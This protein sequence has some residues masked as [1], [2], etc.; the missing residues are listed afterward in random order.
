M[1]RVQHIGDKIYNSHPSNGIGI[2]F[3]GWDNPGPNQEADYDDY[4][5]PYIQRRGW[6]IV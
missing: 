6:F 4:S 2:F 1:A 3:F 5:T